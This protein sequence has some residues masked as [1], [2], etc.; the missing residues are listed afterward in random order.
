MFEEQSG[1]HE[2]KMSLPIRDSLSLSFRDPEH[3]AI[4]KRLYGLNVKHCLQG[5][6][7]AYV[8]PW[9][10]AEGGLQP[11]PRFLLPVFRRSAVSSFTP[12]GQQGP[13]TNRAKESGTEISVKQSLQIFPL[14][15]FSQVSVMAAMKL[16]N[17][18]ELYM[19]SVSVITKY[20]FLRP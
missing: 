10:V 4:L 18:E 3:C 8:F 5:L 14:S 6:S 1:Y 16:D 9:L 2:T 11:Y 19:K 17:T 7:G 12:S 20:T 13:R 15:C